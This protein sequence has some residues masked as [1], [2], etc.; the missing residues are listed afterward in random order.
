[1]TTKGYLSLLAE[2]EALDA[3]IAI[4]RKAERD[5]AIV[6]IRDLM[7]DLDIGVDD[8]HEKAAKRRSTRVSN[9]PMYRDP[10]SGKTWTG[11]GRQPV[12][13]G[14]DPARFLIQPDLLTNQSDEN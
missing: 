4:A 5:A 1:M 2:L 10:I 6:Q 7:K 14:D 11:K 12:W 9:T 13:L 8:L 3:R